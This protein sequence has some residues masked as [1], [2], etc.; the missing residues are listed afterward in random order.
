MNADQVIV[1]ADVARTYCQNVFE[2][3]GLSAKDALIV[4]D[5]LIDADL[6]GVSIHGLV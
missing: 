1:R 3:A 6:R 5:A 4:A 2:K